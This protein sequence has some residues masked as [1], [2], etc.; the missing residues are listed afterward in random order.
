MRRMSGGGKYANSGPSILMIAVHLGEQPPWLQAYLRSCELNPSVNWLLAVDWERLPETPA[1]VRMRR[2]TKDE[3]ET[4]VT[5]RAGVRAKLAEP[6]KLCDYKVLYGTLFREEC[7]GYDFWGFTDLDIIYGDIRRFVTD[8][9]LRRYDVIT[10]CRY[11]CVGHFTIMRNNKKLNNLYRKNRHYKKLLENESYAGFD[12]AA[13]T[14]ILNRDKI[15]RAVSWYHEYLHVNSGDY[16][17][18]CFRM[19]TLTGK[20]RKDYD[21]ANVDKWDRNAGTDLEPGLLG[22]C[23]WSNG[24]LMHLDTGKEMMYLHF[25]DWQ[26]RMGG[27]SDNTHWLIVP[28]G[29]I[30]PMG[31]RMIRILTSRVMRKSGIS[32]A[33][34][35]LLRS[36]LK[37]S[38]LKNTPFKCYA[39]LANYVDRR[40]GHLGMILKSRMPR[41]YFRINKK[42]VKERTSSFGG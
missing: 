13:F 31:P 26:D 2:I 42:A 22:N 9:V 6:R 21:F 38:A 34:L 41:V 32:P 19:L 33:L 37:L 29:V 28:E 30:N 7:S 16:R 35:L 4:L 10:A 15:R 25:R 17:W 36:Y 24:K 12:E 20:E 1:N 11:Y 23:L 18:F 8:D 27:F 14:E 40:G 3:I 5:K 39:N